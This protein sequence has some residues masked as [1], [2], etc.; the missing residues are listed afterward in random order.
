MPSGPSEAELRE[1]EELGE[2]EA[3]GVAGAPGELVD[4]AEDDEDEDDDGTLDAGPGG[5]AGGLD[6]P[7]G[8]RTL[9]LLLL[10]A[11]ED[12]ADQ[13][14]FEPLESGYRVRFRRSGRLR[15]I[16]RLPQAAGEAAIE[17]AMVLAEMDLSRRTRAQAGTLRLSIAGEPLEIDAATAP[18]ALGMALALDIE[19]A[20]FR[21]LALDGL[22]LVPG[23]SHLLRSLLSLPPGL[24]VVSAPPAE[25]KTTL[26]YAMLR[27]IDR[28]REHVVTLERT[29]RA[30]VEGAIQ[31]AGPDYAAF[32]AAAGKLRPDRVLADDLLAGAGPLAS[33]D[34]VR[35][36][37]DLAL[38]GARVVV[39]VEAPDPISAVARLAGTGVE[40]R[41]LLAPLRAI[42]GMRLVRRICP[43]CREELEADAELAGALGLGDTPGARRLSLGIGCWECSGT[44]Y[45]GRSA[46]T[47]VIVADDPIKDALASL[48]PARVR[49]KA[50]E[51]GGRALPEKALLALR[52][53]LTSV[54]QVE[55]VT[56]GR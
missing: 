13:V 1:I 50:A 40:T 37:L 52:S 6:E 33:R 20:H 54:S 46:L 25:G 36:V 22:A 49:A 29:V 3:G 32:A 45:R 26:L 19:E 41:L 12:R 31:L 17:R 2:L 18:A 44:G 42:A 51:R 5:A 21:L 38:A 27:D 55:R 34:E 56:Q 39:A 47:E 8:E 14:I 30:R 28:A 43:R 24:V 53:G 48:D 4:D 15:E 11:A 16:A 7:P 35:L 9:N 23:D 10:Q